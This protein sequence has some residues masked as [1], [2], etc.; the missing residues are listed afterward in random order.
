MDDGQWQQ[1][2]AAFSKALELP[3][4]E[5]PAFLESLN[6]PAVRL[7]V[8]SLLASQHAGNDPLESPAIRL[9]ADSPDEKERDPWIGKNIGGYHVISALGHG[10]MGVV[11]RAIRVGDHF[12]KHVALKL[13]RSGIGS[14]GAIRRF[15]NERQ[16]LASLEHANIAR[17]LDGGTT[18]D[19]LPYLVMEY[20]DGKPIDQ[21]CDAQ[22]LAIPERLRLFQ[23]ICSAVQY[24][25]QN[26][27]VHRDI[28]PGNIL[29]TADG[30]PK[31]LD[32]GIAKL[33]E[34][35]LYFQ[36]A[37]PTVALRPM[38]P[39]YASPEQVR[40][41]PITT[42][43][44]IYSLGVVLYRLLTGHP[45]Y[46]V[47]KTPHHE[48]AQAILDAQPERPSSVLRREEEIKDSDGQP[49]HLT[50]EAVA[51]ARG[52]HPESLRR[53][54]SGDLDNIVLKAL[55]KDPTRR[56][57]SVAQFSE[58]IGRH[59][60][61]LPVIARKDTVG[62]RAS[63]FV[64]RHRTGVAAVA[65]IFFLLIAGMITT[66]WQARVARSQRAIANQRFEDVRALANSLI[67]DLH[68]AIQDLPGSTPARRLLVQKALQYLD[69]LSKEPG[70]DRTLLLDLA[71]AYQKLGDVQGNSYVANLG[72]TAGASAS[73]S[74]ALQIY[75]SLSKGSAQDIR[76]MQQLSDLHQRICALRLRSG[77][78]AGALEEA[79][80]CLTLQQS[81][82]DSN[83][84]DQQARYDLAM[85]FDRM[86][87]VLVAFGRMDEALAF[88]RKELAILEAIA[89][90]PNAP[91]SQRRA[92]S[93]CNKRIGGIL[94]FGGNLSEALDR[95]E[96]ALTIDEAL[97]AAEP[98][99]ARRKRDLSI[100]Y[101]NLGDILAKRGDFA[102]SLE[103][104]RMALALDEA[105]AAADSADARSR[106]YL[107]YN[108]RRAGKALLELGKFAEARKS[109]ARSLAIT[110]DL[111]RI[112][113]M[114]A[115][116]RA[117]LAES[118]A[119]FG[120]LGERI[121]S[122]AANRPSARRSW[123]EARSWYER[124]RSVWLE[125]QKQ[126]ALIGLY[127]GKPQELAQAISRC[128][129]A[130]AKWTTRNQ[131]F[132]SKPASAP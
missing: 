114:N 79:Q 17:L 27:V 56:Y 60:D 84:K 15:K 117:E 26:L 72:D 109:Y 46:R 116:I 103:R 85:G 105:L 18:E 65:A 87:D 91:A 44:D 94:E 123:R 21:Y 47:D 4:A 61:G 39:E 121:A 76:T 12:L 69:T 118:Y 49:V 19:G 9:D 63:K 22:R 1:I 120:G 45:P 59:L 23:S 30:V 42:S 90:S 55:R 8:A 2:K 37:D 11:Y 99:N 96:Q 125:L 50:P 25:H 113:P 130:L 24:A 106:D 66:T 62:Y 10:G 97:A 31:L 13:V 74:K 86:G 35:Q 16:I 129:S 68:D 77:D 54:L 58:D 40:G 132:A 5:H 110:E 92:L 28:K 14:E 70:G 78:P 33:L 7:E 115:K 107:A 34:P 111:S 127:K 48:L 51:T 128:D 131:R 101:V 53:R 64:R 20:I 57:V 38:T 43:S 81:I 36:T 88:H 93:V 52:E 67:F 98:T 73:Y 75:E 6:D 124:S 3:P 71:A 112:D 41:E 80:K 102:G 108:S 83:P 32:F 95:Y 126:N 122:V 29:V 104:Y 89:G 82:A 119:S 100:S